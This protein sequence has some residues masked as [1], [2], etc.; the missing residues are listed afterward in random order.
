[1]T[2]NKAQI[3]RLINTTAQPRNK[4]L[5]MC[6]L[7]VRKD[8]FVPEA[9]YGKKARRDNRTISPISVTH[10]ATELYANKS[11]HKPLLPF[12]GLYYSLT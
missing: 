2:K 5:L 7:V 3:V 9:T 4:R 11:Y 10:R 1:M 8:L 6:G 12:S